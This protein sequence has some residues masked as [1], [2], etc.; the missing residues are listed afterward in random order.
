MLLLMIALLQTPAESLTVTGLRAPVEIIRDRAGIP[1]IYA[2]N[3]HDLFF[4]Q[5]YNA[6]RDRL[7]QLELWRRSATGTVAEMLGPQ[8]LKRDLGARKVRRL[9]YFQPPDPDLSVDS[10]VDLSL[11]TSPIL[12]LYRAFREPLKFTPE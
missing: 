11:I 3:E 10:A 12:E 8:E 4:A 1:H 7:F 2:R 6:A 5:G 9:A